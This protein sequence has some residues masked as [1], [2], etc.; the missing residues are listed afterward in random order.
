MLLFHGGFYFRGL[1]RLNFGSD[2]RDPFDRCSCYKLCC[3]G[4]G[5]N[6][7]VT[8][9]FNGTFQSVPAINRVS[10]MLLELRGS[11][12]LLIP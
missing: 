2:P 11:L 6:F 8:L 3:R 5:R 4:C 7:L 10:R 1:R 12:F 9:G